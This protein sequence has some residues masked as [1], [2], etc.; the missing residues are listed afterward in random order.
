MIKTRIPPS[1]T[2]PMHIWTARVALFN[3]LFAKQNW[4]KFLI[5]VEDTDKER[6]KSE[7]TEEILAWLAW[8]GLKED[9]EI[10][11]QSKNEEKHKQAIQKLIDEWKAYYAWESPKELEQLRQKAREEKKWFVF[12][13]PTYTEEQIEQFKKEWRN[14][15]VRFQV[16]ENRE[17]TY[18]DLVKWEIKFN[19]N[20]IW[21]FVIAKSDGSVIFYLA[22]VVDDH[23]MWITHVIRW[24]DHIPNTPKQILLYEALNYEIPIFGH[25]PLL[26]NPNKS[27]MSK[28]DTSDVF[29]T[30]KK[31][32]QE[33]FLS[34]A[35][36]NFIA[37]LWWHTADDR[38]FFTFGELMKEFSIQ[39]VQSS[40]AVYDFQR[41]IHFN[42]EHIR[43]LSVEK[44]LKSVKDY[45]DFMLNDKVL[46]LNEEEHQDLI[47]DLKFWKK[48]IDEGKFDD[49]EYA[50]KWLP[51][52]QVR[53]QTL[54]QFVQFTKYLFEYVPVSDEI[55]YNKKMKVTEEVVKKHLPKI[56]EL[57]EN[58]QDW[59]DENL[60]NLIVSYN[61]EN[62][63]KNWQ[64]LWPIRAILSWVQASP[65]AFE[66]M[67][68]LWKQESINRLKKRINSNWPIIPHS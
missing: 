1:P 27:K 54:K 21:D 42:A 25:L 4:W 63:L 3:Y 19:T 58:T 40:N 34:E 67:V 57:L 13:K 11:Y 65:G 38:E 43:H 10:V 41:A 62:W 36:V 56:I 55:L 64:T 9:E 35:V 16:P 61:K 8:L 60:K 12:R 29:V 50:Q 37:L 53:L 39:R 66:L 17:V 49:L 24:E 52:V 68:I 23:L 14:P 28:R 5:R 7:H 45:V 31:F 33:G 2:W 47:N 51:E 18:Q 20:E 48:I 59:S 22:N 44:F 15:V 26:L 32:A 30:V 6:S 46:W